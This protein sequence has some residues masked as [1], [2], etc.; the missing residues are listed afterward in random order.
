MSLIIPEFVTGS[1]KMEKK[2]SLVVK[3][4]FRRPTRSNTTN[5]PNSNEKNANKSTEKI[6]SLCVHG[7]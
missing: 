3:L 4:N 2:K 7:V 1:E 6:R 5:I